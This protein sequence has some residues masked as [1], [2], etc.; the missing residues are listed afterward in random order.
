MTTVNSG[1]LLREVARL[2]AR[3]QSVVADCNSTA[4]DQCYLLAELGRSGTLAMTELGRRVRREKSWVSRSVEA[5]AA[6][7]LVVKEP[8]PGDSRTCLV[9]L[10]DEGLQSV[11]D[12]NAALDAHAAQLLACLGERDRAAVE[13]SLLILL[14]VMRQDQFASY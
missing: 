7:G 10:T 6:R 13:R 8:N 1:N 2:L 12:C 4:N 14:K 3:A 9:R 5:L 11:N